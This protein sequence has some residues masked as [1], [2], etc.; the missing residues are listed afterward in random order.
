MHA[1]VLGSLDA[2]LIWP[3]VADR[4]IDLDTSLKV[5]RAFR[6]LHDH[7]VECERDLGKGS[8]EK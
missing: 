1:V 2:M 6:E 5:V 3:Q 8:L 7:A 4:G